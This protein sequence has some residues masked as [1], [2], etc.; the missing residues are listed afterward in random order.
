M[1]S[2]YLQKTLDTVNREILLVKLDSHGIRGLANS[3][4]QSFLQSRTQ[5]I[6]LAGHSSSVKTVTCGVRQGS[7]LSPLLFVFI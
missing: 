4:L 1:W 5:H 3:G 6:N 7:T 2:F